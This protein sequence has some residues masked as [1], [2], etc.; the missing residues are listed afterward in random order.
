M[1]NAKEKLKLQIGKVQTVH[2]RVAAQ[3]I[4]HL[5]KGIY[6]NPANCIKELINNS[7]DADATQVTIRA[8]PEFDV[9]SITDD[10][11]GMNYTDFKNRFL[12]ISRSSKRDKGKRTKKFK[13]PII[14]KIGIGFVSVSEICDKMIV[15]SSK[16]GEKYKFQAEIDFGRFKKMIHKK[17]D[18]YE[19]S[20]V[21]LTNLKER[22]NAHYTIILLNGLTRDFKELL[23]DKDIH[24][25]GIKIATFDGKKFEKIITEIKKRL[26]DSSKDIGGYW[27]MMLEIANTVPIPYLNEYPI[28][29]KNTKWFKKETRF[30]N[31]LKKTVE[32][33]QFSVDFDGVIIEK[34]IFLPVEK[35]IYNKKESYDIYTFKEKFDDF[36]DGSKLE[37]RGYIYNQKRQILPPQLRGI[38]VRI[39]NTSI[40]VPDPDFLG[41]PYAEKLFLP[42]VFGEIYIDEGLEE[43]MNINRNSFIIT[44]PHF[45]K[46]KN[47]LHKKLHTEVFPRC[48]S[49]YIE[50]KEERDIVEKNIREKHIKEY[51]KDVLSKN[52]NIK[53]PEKLGRSPVEI[54]TKKKEVLIFKGHP[55]F[56]KRNKKEKEFLED[57]LI[58]FETSYHTAG[59]DLDKMKDYFISSLKKWVNLKK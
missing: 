54:D 4:Q 23:E 6:S 29:V 42:W 36:L 25:A 53:F 37:F 47:F 40:G 22:E 30:I 17:K 19:L 3:I 21:K 44:H 11:Q 28:R 26:L 31:N 58:L 12:W 45:R 34:P 1:N 49:R 35:D 20:E 27:R 32:K 51:L 9:F 33:F 59:G 13:R 2:M 7:F 57:I 39:K 10:G 46:L 15:I 55:V 8:K 14:G 5:S 16:I 52:F 38:V 48:R 41:Y 43:A 18:F 50:R 56:K 24:E